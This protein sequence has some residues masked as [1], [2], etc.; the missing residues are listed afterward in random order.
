SS[1]TYYDFDS[2]EEIQVTTGGS[3]ASQQGAGVQINFVTK[4]GGNT[5][6]GSSRFFDTNQKFESINIGNKEPDLG[7][8]GGNPIQDIQDFG[9]EMGGPVVKNRMWYWGAL[10]KNKTDV[11]IVNFYDT[12]LGATCQTLAANTSLAS[13]KDASGGYVYSVQDL[14][15]CY[16]TDNTI[17]KNF[18]GKLQFQENLA[19]KSTFVVVNGIKTRN[20]RGADAFTPLIPT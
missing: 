5:I 11:G 7:A 13:S 2:F 10:S 3:D 17:L 9:F 20:A 18:N 12:S 15:D 4:S 19:N 1:P 16:K 14:W 8:S 6:R